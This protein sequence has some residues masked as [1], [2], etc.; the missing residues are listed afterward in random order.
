[1]RISRHAQNVTARFPFLPQT[2]ARAAEENRFPRA[3]RLR[4]RFAVHEAEHQ[5]FA[6]A[7]V[8]NNSRYKAP[9]LCDM[10]SPVPS[11]RKINPIKNKKPAGLAAPAGR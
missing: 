11:L 10:R 2:I 3:L 7:A 6:G 8:L 1:M 4:E 5:D 9:G